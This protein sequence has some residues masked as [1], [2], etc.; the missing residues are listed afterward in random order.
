M[1]NWVKDYFDSKLEKMDE[2]NREISRLQ[3]TGKYD[4]SDSKQ[5]GVELSNKN[6]SIVVWYK[7]DSID[8]ISSEI[9]SLSIDKNI[10]LWDSNEGVLDNVKKIIV[11]NNI[12][13][14]G[15]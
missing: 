13:Y 9:F 7:D 10:F 6:F 15:E 8:G 14:K 2:L 4:K 3:L 12:I 5:A 11:N 1:F